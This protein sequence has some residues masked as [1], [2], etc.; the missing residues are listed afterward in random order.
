MSFLSLSLS[1]SQRYHNSE[2]NRTSSFPREGVLDGHELIMIIVIIIIIIINNQYHHY[3]IL[4]I[5]WRFS[6]WTR[7]LKVFLSILIFT[8]PQT[9]R[10]GEIWNP[11]FFVPS[12]FYISCIFLNYT[13]WCKWWS[14]LCVFVFIIDI[15]R[16]KY[17]LFLILIL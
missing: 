17:I 1:L 16:E 3:Y 13:K 6:C 2:Q 12:I 9:N 7:T 15:S 10:A 11:F 14:I 4:I 5:S 8:L